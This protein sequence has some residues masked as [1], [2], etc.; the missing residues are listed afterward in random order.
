MRRALVRFARSV[1]LIVRETGAMRSSFGRWLFFALYDQY[2]KWVEDPFQGLLNQHPEL[3]RGGNII[4]VG[5]NLG[6]TVEIFARGV[7]NPFQVF[8]FEPDPETFRYLG[9]RIQKK[10]LTAVRTF[11]FAV[12]AREC[13]TQL[14]RSPL[15]P[16]DHRVYLPAGRTEFLESSKH[17]IDVK[18]V[19]LDAFCRQHGILDSVILVKIDVQGFEFEVLKGMMGLFEKNPELKVALELDLP[20]LQEAGTSLEEIRTFF[21]VYG[22]TYELVELSGRLRKIADSELDSIVRKNG[23][24]DILIHKG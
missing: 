9:D 20:S 23:Y 18:Q 11:P 24:I 10:A 1:Y 21:G 17:P 19:T 12:G 22:L 5:A 13:D 7:Q 14:Y 6:Y 16:A 3:F 4:D 8:A 2:K 15:H